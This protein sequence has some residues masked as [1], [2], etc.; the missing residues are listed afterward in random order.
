MWIKVE[1]GKIHIDDV[2]KIP[3]KEGVYVHVKYEETENSKTI[4]VNGERKY[5]IKTQ[6][7]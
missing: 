1:N 2:V 5:R 3:Y 7:M 6:N 4:Y